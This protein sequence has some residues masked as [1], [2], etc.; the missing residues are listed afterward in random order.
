[1][2]C[3]ICDRESSKEGICS[4]HLKAYEN[5]TN[6]F[7]KW[8]KALNVSWREYLSQI[9]ENSSAG[10]LVKETAEYLLENEEK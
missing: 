5:L 1:M 3:K 10:N 2:K 4:L 9:V 8:R 7:D 6:T